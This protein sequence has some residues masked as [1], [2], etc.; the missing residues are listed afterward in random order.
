MK[1]PPMSNRDII[2]EL[3]EVIELLVQYHPEDSNVAHKLRILKWE[4]K[5][6]RS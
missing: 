5:E 1:L 4:I 3:I 6:T 2:D